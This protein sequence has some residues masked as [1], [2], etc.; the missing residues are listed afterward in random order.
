M[1]LYAFQKSKQRFWSPQLHLEIYDTAEGQSQIKGLFGSNPSIWTLF[2]FL[3]FIVAILF[4]SASTWMYVN[5][6]LDKPYILPTVCMSFLLIT[7]FILYFA[8]RMG[9]VA[10]KKEMRILYLFME[11]TIRT[12]A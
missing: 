8:G 2:M 4:I 3:H 12:I 6:S 7:W 10:G 11:N 9:R 5:V 1:F